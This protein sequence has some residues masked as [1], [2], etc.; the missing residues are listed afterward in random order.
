MMPMTKGFSDAEVFCASPTTASVGF[1]A[2]AACRLEFIAMPVSPAAPKTVA[3]RRN[4]RRFV[5]SFIRYS[6]WLAGLQSLQQCVEPG[7]LKVVV[8]GQRVGDLAVGHHDE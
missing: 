7:L 1:S 2:S 8:A 5:R 4:C 6:V 3:S